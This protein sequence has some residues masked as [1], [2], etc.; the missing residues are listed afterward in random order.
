MI[1]REGQKK[2]L[3]QFRKTQ[4]PLKSKLVIAQSHIPHTLRCFAFMLCI[5]VN[6]STKHLLL[7]LNAEKIKKDT[8]LIVTFRQMV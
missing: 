1:M 4:E 3:F 8:M 5:A 6:L 7:S 2:V